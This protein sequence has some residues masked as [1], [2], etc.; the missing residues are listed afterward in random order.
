MSRSTTKLIP[1]TA[2]S[3]AVAWS[4]EEVDQRAARFAAKLKAQAERENETEEEAESSLHQLGYAEGYSAGFAAGQAQGERE[5]RES[6]QAEAAQTLKG[7]QEGV[8][9]EATEH[10]QQAVQAM[11]Q[12]FD[13]LQHM[14]ADEVLQ[15]VCALARQVVRRELA[16]SPDAVL[17]VVREA[18]GMLLAD[19]QVAQVRM[20]PEDVV[21]VADEL[22]S[23]YETHKLQFV[24]DAAVQRGGCVLSS[25]GMTV[26]AT[27]QARWRKAVYALGVEQDWD[28]VE[29]EAGDADIADQ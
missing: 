25:A 18:V 28:S 12:Q 20:H 10:I 13:A 21:L 29:Q 9:R 24:P 17:P 11:Q 27:L 14:M 22:R 4:F 3:H 19:S 7:Y 15:L 6:A 26:D 23:H 5:G 2:V 16:L 8:G 1:H